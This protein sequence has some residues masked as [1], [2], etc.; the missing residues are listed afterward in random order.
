MRNTQH[1][2]YIIALLLS[3][4]MIP[5]ARAD[6]LVNSSFEDPDLL[7]GGQRFNIG[8]T[9]GSGWTVDS[10]SI[11]V[12]DSPSDG[13]YYPS[14]SDG[15]NILFTDTDA[16]SISQIVT[17]LA[18]T[19]Y[20]FTIDLAGPL[21][22]FNSNGAYL[23]IDV[24]QGG[25]TIIGGPMTFTRPVGASWATQELL[26]SSTI[27]GSYQISLTSRQDFINSLDKAV[28]TTA[29]PEP[30]ALSLCVFGATLFTLRRRRRA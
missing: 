30:T 8:E 26:F 17:L 16:S 15:Q 21:Q 12:I 18:S 22:D 7:G 1:S 9:I 19:Q 4:S 25:N 24:L 3:L 2:F 27:S 20:R 10:G 13:T 29:V 14:A 6:L 5:L 11:Q 23:D 28:L